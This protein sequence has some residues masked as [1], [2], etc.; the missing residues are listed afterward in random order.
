MDAPSFLGLLQRHRAI[1]VIRAPSPEV[2]LCLAT[3]AAAG[4]IRLL[5]ITWNSPS[6]AQIVAELRQRLPHCTIGA[7]TL[8]TLGDAKAAKAAGATFGF[9][10]YTDPDL[11]AWSQSHHWP[12]VPGALTPNEIVRAW[13]AGA[14][15]VKV[16]PVDALGGASYI[17]SLQGPL[18]HIPL[19]PTG[20]VTVGNGAALVQAGAVGVGLST[21]LFA[22]AAIAQGD[23]PA[24]TQ[25]ARQLVSCLE[26]LP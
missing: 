24:I 7:G 2:G 14:P 3:A 5:E 21:G 6:P 15:A 12:L 23:W 19:V 10:P 16:F 22:K 18:G 20:G 8:L 9:A 11:L 13:Q 25:T 1:A 4:G 17:R 26:A